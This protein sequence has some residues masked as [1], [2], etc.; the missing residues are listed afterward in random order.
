[1]LVQVVMQGVGP[2]QPYGRHA[3]TLASGAVK[4]V[5]SSVGRMQGPHD[6]ARGIDPSRV[7]LR[8]RPATPFKAREQ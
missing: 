5:R 7:G 1:M 2:E 6:G 3:L 8:G 4:W